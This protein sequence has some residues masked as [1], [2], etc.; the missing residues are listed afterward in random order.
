MIEMAQDTSNPT[1]IK[2]IGVGGGG[3]NAVD[4]MIEAKMTSVQF[5]AINTD[6]QAL[7]RSKAST[8]IQ[9]GETTTRG[10]GAGADPEKGQAAA[11]ED[12]DKLKEI[13]SD[14]DMV[15]ITAGMGGGTGT[16]A[17]PVVA[18]I[19]REQGCLTVAVVTKPFNFEG[20]KR[21]KQAELGI[22]ALIDHVDTL[23]TIPNQNLLGLVDK[24]MSITDCFHIADSVLTQGVRG[25]SDL[26]TKTGTINVDFADV[27]TVMASKGNAVM[28][29]ASAKSGEQ[30]VVELAEKVITNPLIEGASIEGASGLLINITHGHGTSLHDLDE[31]IK[32]ITAKTDSHADI[33]TG[34]V[35]DETMENEINITVIATGFN[36]GKTIYR[37]DMFKD[38]ENNPSM[39][40]AEEGSEEN[41]SQERKIHFL[42][43][44]DFEEEELILDEPYEGGKVSPLHNVSDFE[45][46][47]FLR[48]KAQ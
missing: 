39:V 40:E 13:L 21:L 46:P 36:K 47:T 41:D 18:R 9:L 6:L 7:N 37:K 16:G 31:I 32:T 17:A 27:K 35:L 1:I 48:K 42:S 5:I 44:E 22:G 24:K 20:P 28:G 19:A 25:I 2:V 11:E 10:L 26:I 34:F 8:Q 12:A 3:C 33:I 38:D 4:R 14:A 29:M 23:I 15:F 45:I 43:R 30:N